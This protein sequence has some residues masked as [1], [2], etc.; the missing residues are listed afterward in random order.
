LIASSTS[1]AFFRTGAP[2]VKTYPSLAQNKRP[3]QHHLRRDWWVNA[4]GV[5]Q[6]FAATKTVY[7]FLLK[8]AQTAF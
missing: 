7:S 2:F 3:L 8:T 1:G 4:P 6:R 5:Q